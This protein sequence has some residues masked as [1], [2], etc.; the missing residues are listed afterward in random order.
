MSAR[1]RTGV[2]PGPVQGR[3]GAAPTTEGSHFSGIGLIPMRWMKI[4][5][6][7][8]SEGMGRIRSGGKGPGEIRLSTFMRTPRRFA[9]NLPDRHRL[10]RHMADIHP[11]LAQQI[12]HILEQ[13]MRR[14][15]KNRII[16]LVT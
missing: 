5:P 16:S 14:L 6:F 11:S 4:C 12:C 8:G 13:L 3:S 2:G 7:R 1:R 9:G 15:E 10:L